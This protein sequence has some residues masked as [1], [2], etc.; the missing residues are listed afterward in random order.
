MIKIKETKY[1]IK[2]VAFDLD[3]VVYYGNE[4]ASGI[5][6]VVDEISRMGL[7]IFYVTN[8]S[9]KSR[10]EIASKLVGFGI[11]VD[12]DHIYSSGYATAV[13]LADLQDITKK[14]I[15]TIGSDGLKKEIHNQGLCLVEELPCD[16]LIVGYDVNFSYEKIC[17]GL[18]AIL[19]GARFV[20]CNLVANYPGEGRQLKPGCFAMVAAIE[21]ASQKEP[22]I[23]IGKPNIHMIEKLAIKHRLKPDEIVMV[24]DSVEYDITMA[25]HFGCHSVLLKNEYNSGDK[26]DD[27]TPEFTINELTMLTQIIEYNFQ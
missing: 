21:A 2:A 6:K 16:F 8:N 3:G 23:V 24:G 19:G 9:A 7:E 26:A 17:I 20:A 18:D 5:L 27:I 25:K 12:V 1:K 22:D 10:E 13:Y 14:K 4:L 15:L 11:N